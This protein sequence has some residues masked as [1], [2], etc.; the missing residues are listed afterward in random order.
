MVLGETASIE[1]LASLRGQAG[2]SAFVG[3]P[4]YTLRAARQHRR[5][6]RPPCWL[7]S[8]RRSAGRSHGRRGPPLAPP[9]PGPR[10][11][12][13]APAPPAS[14]RHRP[15][16]S[17]L[18]HTTPACCSPVDGRDVALEQLARARRARG[19]ARAQVEL[20]LVAR[21][22]GRAEG[23][24]LA[25]LLAAQVRLGP[26]RADPAGIAGQR[27]VAPGRR[28]RCGVVARRRLDLELHTISG[29]VA[30]GHMWPSGQ[31]V[32]FVRS[33]MRSRPQTRPPGQGSQLVTSA[34]PRNCVHVPTGQSTQVT[35]SAIDRYGTCPPGRRS[36][37]R[38]RSPGTC[39]PRG[40]AGTR[41]CS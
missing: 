29:C 40:R 22:A 39:S 27:Q 34:P 41:P 7:R 20:A 32:A 5:R 14:R 31:P 33:A 23:A 24:D 18:M 11:R 17:F 16:P 13:P 25:H 30:S 3:L 9:R 37:C 21:R 4:S 28:R 26:A 12:R 1:A 38:C 15:A 8:R 6:H 36:G 35:S 2:K 19:A 10:A